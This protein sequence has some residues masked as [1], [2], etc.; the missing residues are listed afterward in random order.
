[1]IHHSFIL[2]VLATSRLET[3]SPTKLPLHLRELDAESSSR[4]PLGTNSD[5]SLENL[6]QTPVI[7]GV[8][9]IKGK[10][11][12]PHILNR[13]ARQKREFDGE[14]DYAIFPV[15][16]PAV[17]MAF[18]TGK[19]ASEIGDGRQ[20]PG[21][22]SGICVSPI[23]AVDDGVSTVLDGTLNSTSVFLRSSGVWRRAFMIL[24]NDHSSFVLSPEVAESHPRV[25]MK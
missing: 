22:K 23:S 6:S 25:V 10:Q 5:L 4:C 8:Q 2:P 7:V 24:S 20:D 1:M 14:V 9:D 13:D 15:Y 21:S 18:D 12:R 11:R 19:V 17:D 16:G 3:N